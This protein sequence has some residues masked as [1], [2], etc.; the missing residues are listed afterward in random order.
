M[1][2]ETRL[3]EKYQL[4]PNFK[5]KFKPQQIKDILRE[6]LVEK[7]TGATYQ[8]EM[9]AHLSK[10]LANNIRDRLTT[11]LD[12][13]RYKYVVNVFIG[14]QKGEGIKMGCRCFWDDETDN[15]ATDVYM[16]DALFCIAT[17]FGVYN[18]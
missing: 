11:D 16:N 18:Y 6:M 12:N 4:R 17:V 8:S 5:Q 3:P 13:P 2:D 14:E 9:V 10:E 7:L 15:Y 1:V